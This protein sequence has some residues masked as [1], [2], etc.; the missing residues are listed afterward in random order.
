MLPFIYKIVYFVHTLSFRKSI[1]IENTF[2]IPTERCYEIL[3]LNSFFFSLLRHCFGLISYQVGLSDGARYKR[4]NST[5]V[6]LVHDRL[7]GFR[8]RLKRFSH[9]SWIHVTNN[10]KWFRLLLVIPVRIE[11]KTARTNSGREILIRR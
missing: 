11:I 4:I 7:D 1:D 10:L 9:F 2:S 8:L 6:Q 5:T 3:I